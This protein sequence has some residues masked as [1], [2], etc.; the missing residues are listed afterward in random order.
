[1]KKLNSQGT[2]PQTNKQRVNN[3][4][5][6]ALLLLMVIPVIS[7]SQAVQISSGGKLTANYGAQVIGNLQ[8]QSCAG[9]LFQPTGPGL[10]SI[11]TQDIQFYAIY[12]TIHKAGTLL[13]T[14]D[15]RVKENFRSIDKP[16]SK[17]LQMDGLKYDFISTVPD[18]MKDEKEKEKRKRL[19]KDKLGFIAQ[20]LQSILP[21]A[22]FYDDGAD[23][24]YIDYIAVIPVIVEAMKE[25]QEQIGLLESE[26]ELLKGKNNEK[27]AFINAE[28]AQVASLNQNIPNPFSSNTLIEMNI[29]KSVLRA[30]L[31]IYNMQGEQIKKIAVN[32]RGNTSVTIE[33]NTL[34]AGMYLYTLI[35]D[36]KEVDTKKMI[37]TR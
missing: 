26:I 9:N 35:T 10:G 12:G 4:K 14:S 20:D 13:L 30:V 22:V 5:L 11:G 34:K 36:N 2:I 29:P 7:F 19:E 33:G 21:E 16:L 17:I 37:L 3:L 6:S 15:K 31:Y 27:S 25:Q 23:K 18:S 24:Y 8:I 32:E 28:D 1:M